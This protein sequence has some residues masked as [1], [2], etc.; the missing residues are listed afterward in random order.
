MEG[1][2]VPV[3]ADIYIGKA[4]AYAS[5]SPRHLAWVA[6]D[7]DPED[8]R[9]SRRSFVLHCVREWHQTHLSP[10]SHERPLHD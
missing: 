2:E 1:I 5:P 8:R 3:R 7:Y 10:R 9:W 6:E 4:N